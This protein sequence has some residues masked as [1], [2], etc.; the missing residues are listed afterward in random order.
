MIYLL[1]DIERNLY[2]LMERNEFVEHFSNKGNWTP[3]I[4]TEFGIAST[5]TI[6]RTKSGKPA[7]WWTS[8]YPQ[9]IDA[10]LITKCRDIEAYRQ[11]CANHPEL[12][13]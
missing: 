6:H 1:H 13:I 11:W 2:V 10:T 9:Y 5:D 12:F 7:N 4:P 8:R 3:D